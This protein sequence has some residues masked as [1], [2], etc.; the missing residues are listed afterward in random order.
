MTRT[1][2]RELFVHWTTRSRRDDM[3]FYFVCPKGV[4]AGYPSAALLRTLSRKERRAVA[5][6][7]VLVLTADR[8]YA[9]HGVR[10]GARLARVARRLHVGRPF[11]IGINTW[12]LVPNGA[13]TGVLKVRHGIVFEVGIADKRLT[14]SGPATLRFLKSFR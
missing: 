3:D 9:L 14:A 2:A 8:F 6:R 13:S 10:N 11:K 7:V 12:Y 1:R 4:R 5:G